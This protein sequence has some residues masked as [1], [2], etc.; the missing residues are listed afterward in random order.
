MK[1]PVLKI[2]DL[3]IKIPIIQ[4]GMGVRVSKA[5]LASAVTNEGGL[6]TISSVG[7]GPVEKKPIEEFA[8]ANS[9]ALIEEIKKRVAQNQKTLAITL[10]K[11]LAE[12]LSD[13][14]AEQGLKTQYLHSEIIGRF[15]YHG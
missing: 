6:G 13:Y 14:L 4:G 2:A 3:E 10:T 11:R 1:L 8:Q 12:D 9:K 15:F 7:L 5:G